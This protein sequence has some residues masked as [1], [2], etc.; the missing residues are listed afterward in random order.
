MVV[1]Q[2]VHAPR[3][4]KSIPRGFGQSGSWVVSMV[5]ARKI[6]FIVFVVVFTT[7]SAYLISG[8]SQRTMCLRCH[9]QVLLQFHQASEVS[10]G[11]RSEQEIPI[12]ILL[13]RSRLSCVSRS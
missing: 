1:G 8:Q 4:A 5:G 7:G 13:Y 9:E 6:V 3:K 12:S 2:T 10:Q 11:E